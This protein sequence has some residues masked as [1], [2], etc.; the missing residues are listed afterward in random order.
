VVFSVDNPGNTV[1]RVDTCRMPEYE[2]IS[3]ISRPFIA[4]LQRIFLS[5]S[6]PESRRIVSSDT[7]GDN[8]LTRFVMRCYVPASEAPLADHS[9]RGLPARIRKRF[10]AEVSAGS[11]QC[12]HKTSG[13]LASAGAPTRAFRG[14][15]MINA[16][17]QPL[18][19]P[20]PPA[21][22]N[23]IVAAEALVHQVAQRR[24]PAGARE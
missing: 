7:S 24:D 10:S 16:V 21:I 15:R 5:T 2:V 12:H 13:S 17:S 22:N 3:C 18:M 14:R 19:Y 1:V 8:S 6:S 23:H 11:I 9:A 20:G 4:N